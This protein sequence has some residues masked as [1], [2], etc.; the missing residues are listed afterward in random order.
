MLLPVSQFLE[1]VSFVIRAYSILVLW[2]LG[3]GCYEVAL[4]IGRGIVEIYIRQAVALEV[5]ESVIAPYG[6]SSI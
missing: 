6:S 1:S 3:D 4:W 5:A 2:G